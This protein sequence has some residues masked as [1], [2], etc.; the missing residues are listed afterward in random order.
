MMAFY[1]VL[2]TFH[3]ASLTFDW[4]LLTFKWVLLTIN[5]TPH[6]HLSRN[7]GTTGEG[8]PSHGQSTQ[9]RDDDD[10]EGERRGE[11]SL[12]I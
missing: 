4:A 5:W 8:T 6:L 3:R 1:W 2:L 9:T 12:G 11:A 10:A 7:R